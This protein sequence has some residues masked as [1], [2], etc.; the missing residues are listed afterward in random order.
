MSLALKPTHAAIKNYY[1]ALNKI[2]QLHFSNEAQVSDAFAKLLA[3][4]GRKLHLT[5]IPQF[6]IRKRTPLQRSHAAALLHRRENITD[7]ALEQFRAHY[8]DPSITKWDIFHY[9]YAVLHHPEYRERYA[10]NL[11]RELPRIPFAS[12][13][14]PSSTLSSRAESRDLLSANTQHRRREEF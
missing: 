9:I 14:T 5:F 6:P 13:V 3:D 4:C 12:S 8:H 2:G 10:A 7:W 11:R 1:A